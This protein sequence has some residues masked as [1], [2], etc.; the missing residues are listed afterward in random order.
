MIIDKIKKDDASVQNILS[1][2]TLAQITEFIQLASENGCTNVLAMLMEYK[3]RNY[4][5][6]DPMA[7]FSLDL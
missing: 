7:E 3:N 4:A 6:F 1:G 2:F 5:D